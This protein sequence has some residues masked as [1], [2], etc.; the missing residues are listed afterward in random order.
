MVQTWPPTRP[1]KA[2]YA[3]LQHWLVTTA[4]ADWKQRRKRR[5]HGGNIAT[6]AAAPA[7]PTRLARA[8]ISNDRHFALRN[9]TS[10]QRHTSRPKNI[11]CLHLL[12]ILHL[13]LHLITAAPGGTLTA[14]SHHADVISRRAL[15]LTEPPARQLCP[16]THQPGPGSF[17][18]STA[19]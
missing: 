2:L 13:P 15:I 5:A 16:A 6:A 19:D 7:N 4:E 1:G 17:G 8:G 11:L 18:I 10:V 14:E 3:W 9:G 12:P